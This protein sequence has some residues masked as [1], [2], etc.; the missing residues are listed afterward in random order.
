MS[1]HSKMVGVAIIGLLHLMSGLA[2]IAV[3]GASAQAGWWL[4]VVGLVLAGL[5]WRD[6]H[7]SQGAS[8]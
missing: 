1:H 7:E 4:V 6:L 8:D 5:A 3:G 2:G